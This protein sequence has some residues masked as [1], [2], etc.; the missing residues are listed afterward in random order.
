[1]LCDGRS[2]GLQRTALPIALQPSRP[3]IE[4]AVFVL[5][6]SVIRNGARGARCGLAAMTAYAVS[7]RAALSIVDESSSTDDS[8]SSRSAGLVYEP[9]SLVSPRNAPVSHSAN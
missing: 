5:P 9:T 6:G 7:P 8:S 1:M 4:C 2:R 3:S